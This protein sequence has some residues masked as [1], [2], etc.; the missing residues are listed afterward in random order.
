MTDEGVI[1]RIPTGINGFDH[2]ALGG[3]P[4]G[5]STLVAGTTGTGKTLFSIEFLARGIQRFDE[6]G[7]FVNFEEKPED[8]RRNAASLGFPIEQWERDGKWTFVDAAADANEEAPIVGAYDFGGLAARI[9]HAIRESGAKRVSLDSLGSIFSRF[10]DPS[11]V[12]LELHR[13]A[14]TLARIE[15]T[16]ILTAE[17]TSEYDGVSR[18]NVEEFVLDNVIILRN[19]L[20]NERRRRTLEV[21]KFRGTAHRTGEW[22]FTID[23]H[24]GI[25]VM[26]LAFLTPLAPASH[27]R[28]SSGNAGL[29]N[30]CGGGVFKDAIVLLTGPSGSGKTLTTLGFTAAGIAAG[31]RCLIYA[32]D[33][34]RAQLGRN[35][36]GWGHDLDAMEAS[37]QL[38]VI[39]D[40]PEVASLEDHFLRIRRAIEDFRPSRL[41]IDTL[42][43]LERV[44]SPRA[45]L[46]FVISLGV[47]VR[48]HQVTTLLT[49][50]PSGRFTPQLTPAI[51][52]EI[53]SLTDVTINLRYVETA[54]EIQRAIA[55]LQTRGSTHDPSIRQVTVDADGLHIGTRLSSIVGILSDTP[56]ISGSGPPPDGP[57]QDE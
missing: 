15:V 4:T 48:H 14:A 55:V 11:Q 17:R 6:S 47:V 51:A 21:V 57:Q 36:S 54:G 53:A 12:R 37:G 35:A 18:H 26:P 29:D 38:R 34:S 27:E 24:D 16:S 7:V 22:L 20:A 52:A 45:L 13:I 30:M 50:A 5:R 44:V 19:I 2:V 23:P 41:V 49:S 31:E 33:E 3:L 10:P 40:Y 25:V 9:E 32:L 1:K 43:A 46:D 56:T 39:C 28:V 42:S 8:V